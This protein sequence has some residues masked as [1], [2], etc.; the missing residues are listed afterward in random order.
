M[1]G[2][3]L[4]SNFLSQISKFLRDS[5]FRISILMAVWNRSPSFKKGTI[6]WNWRIKIA[7]I[8]TYNMCTLQQSITYP[9]GKRKSCSNVPFLGIYYSNEGYLSI[10]IYL[11][12]H[13]LKMNVLVLVPSCFSE[14][15]PLFPQEL[16]TVPWRERWSLGRWRVGW[17][18]GERPPPKKINDE[19]VDE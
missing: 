15:W 14:I 19:C 12:L 10:Y 18:D 1:T 6:D 13:I 8:Y 17:V 4:E 2:V 16:N 9:V 7:F 11:Y 3:F 5:N